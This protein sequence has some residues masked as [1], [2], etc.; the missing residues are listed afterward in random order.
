MHCYLPKYCFFRI[1]TLNGSPNTFIISVETIDL[2]SFIILQQ[3]WTVS[4]TF[5]GF[6]SISNL[7]DHFIFI[8][9]QWNQYLK[10]KI[11]VLHNCVPRLFAGTCQYSKFKYVS[12]QFVNWS[13]FLSCCLSNYKNNILQ[14]L[15]IW[16]DLTV[17]F[18]SRN[19]VQLQVYF[20]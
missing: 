20:M 12:Q 14:N 8:S 2:I 16:R 7:Y 4:F 15:C 19:N 13:S 18:Q 10:H 9:C 6:H 5:R 1:L 11:L 3:T 17:R